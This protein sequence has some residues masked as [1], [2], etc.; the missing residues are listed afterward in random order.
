MAALG[1]CPSPHCC[2][3]GGVLADGASED[4]TLIHHIRQT[5]IQQTFFLFPRVKSEMVGQILTQESFKSSWER[6][7]RTIP[8]DDVPD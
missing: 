7:V 8:K 4:D 3:C 2:R 6:F 1:Q 5:P